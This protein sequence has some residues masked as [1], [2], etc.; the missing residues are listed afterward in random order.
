MINLYNKSKRRKIK[1]LVEIFRRKNLTPIFG[2]ELEFYF[3]QPIN[4]KS[5]EKKL[6]RRVSKEKGDNQYEINFDP[7]NDALKLIEEIESARKK[8]TLIALQEK[9]EVSFASKPFTNDYGS[10]MHFHLNFLENDDVEYFA[11][12]L[13]F[14]IKDYLEYFLPSELDYSRLDEKFMAPTHIC[15]GGNNRTAL[16]R[17]PSSMPKRVEHRL[18][19]ADADPCDVIYSI[20]HAI[21]KGLVEK[22]SL[23]SI[24]K[25]YGNAYDKQ[26]DLEKI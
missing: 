16:I 8:L 22:P 19:G 4:I 1:A 15:Y 24:H 5:L 12:L 26:Y 17:I 10:S 14:Y 20:L 2:A 3:M 21:A 18:A 9:I 23:N 11:K 7:T 6:G 13:C 25:I